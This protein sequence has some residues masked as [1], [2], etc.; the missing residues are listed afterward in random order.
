MRLLIGIPAYNE[1]EAIGKVLQGI[2][3]KIKGI[4]RVDILVVDDGS[5]DNTG[6]K[7]A[8]YNAKV[9][10][11]LINRGL[12]GALKTILR[13]ANSN[14]YDFLV[15]IDAD[16]QHNPSDIIRVVDRLLV[17]DVDVVV[18]SR[19]LKPTQGVWLR[20]FVNWL[21]NILTYFL[22]G[23]W[24]S[25]SQSGF[26][27][28]TRKAFE[29]IN[30]QSDGMEVSSEFFK[31]IDKNKLRFTEVPIDAIYTEYSK[32]KGQKLTNGFNVLM[33]LIVRLLY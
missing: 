13:Y 14:G 15:T 28:F 8:R 27:G 4:S 23:I 24:T 31:E 11:H 6:E 1:H 22:F 12:G 26:R 17:N 9:V 7:A 10:S 20:Y 32:R 30:I 3:R 25:D 29:R 2:P 33:Q 16:G 5:I 19:W 21:A 18:T